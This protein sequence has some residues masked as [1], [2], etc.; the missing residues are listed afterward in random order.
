VSSTT[1][2]GARLSF[3]QAVSLMAGAGVGAGIM[4]IPY[5][6]DRTGF[7]ELLVIVLVAYV[8]NCLIH[9]MLAEVMFR[10]DLNLQVVELMRL[11]LLRGRFA[12]LLWAAFVLLALA[13]VAILTA[14]LA[15][16]SQIVTDLVGAPTMAA[17]LIVYAVSA[18]VVLFGLRAVG[19]AERYG[20]VILVGVVVLMAGGAFAS[21]AEVSLSWLPA[22]GAAEALALYALVMYALYTFYTVPQVVQ[23]LAP[24]RHAAVRAIIGG[25]GINA[26]L[27]L[28]V[29]AVAMAVSNPVSEV[30]SEGIADA[31]GG[32][33]GAAGSA[34][35]L[36]ALITSYWSVS[37]ALADVVRE[38]TGMAR[39]WAWLLATVPSL[40]V[41]LLGGPRFVESLRLAGGA[42]ALVVLLITVPMYLHARRTGRQDAW[43]LG[44]WGSGP[45]LALVV[46]AVLLMAVGSVL[47][48]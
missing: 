16:S 5:L 36:A 20:A 32:W 17:D 19:V 9:L 12:P 37:L 27:V 25:L 26:L 46:V 13:F 48:V 10:T 33:A 6:A 38:R 29:A 1:V 7:L 41:L 28:L 4:A 3:S 42:T 18:G 47:S 24:D 44:R 43:G 30:A 40:L 31:L 8:I 34:F 39:R 11:H 35:V 22:G 15:G 2:V 21:G 14:Y 45:V 23:G